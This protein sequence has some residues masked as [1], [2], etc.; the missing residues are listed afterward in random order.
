MSKDKSLVQLGAEEVGSLAKTGAA[1]VYDLGK[2]FVEVLFGSSSDEKKT[3]DKTEF[4][5]KCSP[6]K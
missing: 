6:K 4:E 5:C 3:S 1:E 2:T